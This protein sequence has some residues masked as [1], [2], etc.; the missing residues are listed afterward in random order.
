MSVHKFTIEKVV[1]ALV[2]AASGTMGR[3]LCQS[4][5]LVFT[6]PLLLLNNLVEMQ[7]ALEGEIVDRFLLRF[8]RLVRQ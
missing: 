2:E 1:D 7:D 3:M 5:C 6:R 8:D 4:L